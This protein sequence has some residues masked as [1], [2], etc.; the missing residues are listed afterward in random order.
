[1]NTESNIGIVFEIKKTII[2]DEM[3]R[4][5]LFDQSPSLIYPGILRSYVRGNNVG[6][7]LLY[8]VQDEGSFERAQEIACEVCQYF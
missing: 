3:A 7:M 2:D 5:L 6:L 1:M 8:D 4:L